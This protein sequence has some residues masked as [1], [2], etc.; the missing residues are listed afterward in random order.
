MGGRVRGQLGQDLEVTA[1]ESLG[2]HPHA[3][4]IPI[5]M[6]SALTCHPESEH[7]VATGRRRASHW[8]VKLCR[9]ESAS[10]LLH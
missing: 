1:K 10:L 9:E 3:L 2:M 7:K 4:A 6:L 8:M 5:P